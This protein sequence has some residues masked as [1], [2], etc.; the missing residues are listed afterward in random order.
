MAKTSRPDSGPTGPVPEANRPGRRPRVQ[1]DKPTG[2]PPTP[3]GAVPRT[4]HFPFRFDPPLPAWR[5]RAEQ[6]TS[7]GSLIKVQAAYDEPFWRADGLSG[8]GFGAGEAVSE[9]YDNS[10]PDGSPPTR[11]TP[12]SP[13]SGRGGTRRTP[14]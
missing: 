1:Q 7:Q 9:I 11:R 10:P 3:P 4:T 8:T 13:P 6:E 2:P 5:M 14:R 12:R